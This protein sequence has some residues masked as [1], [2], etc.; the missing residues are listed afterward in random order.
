MVPHDDIDRIMA[1]ME[2][3][4]DP[5]FG[6]AW[7][8]RQVEDALMLGNCHAVLIDEHG[9]APAEGCRAVGFCLSRHGY[10]EEELLLF[11][12]DPAMRR[13][14]LGSALLQRFIL[15]AQQ[16]GA[17]RLFLE[18]RDGNPAGE[19]YRRHGF[20]PVGRRPR[21]YRAPDGT[22]LDAITFALDCTSGRPGHFLNQPA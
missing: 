17:D 5:A 19:L 22:R 13:R 8:R 21:Y 16:R 10:Q 2:A 18:M 3:A 20:A 15:A 12:V 14:G 11:A 7:N 4:F 1:V 9:K 6:E